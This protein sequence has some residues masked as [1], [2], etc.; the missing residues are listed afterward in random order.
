MDA[1]GAGEAEP[2]AKRARVEAGAAASGGD[3]PRTIVVLNVNGLASRLL[4]KDR[5]NASDAECRDAAAH[6]AAMVTHLFGVAGAPPD[7]VCLTE[8]RDGGACVR[9]SARDDTAPRR[10]GCLQVHLKAR[11]AAARSELEPLDARLVADRRQAE[12]AHAA[13]DTCVLRCQASCL[14]RFL[15]R[16]AL[17]AATPQAAVVAGAAGLHAALV[18]ARREAHRR[19]VRAAAAGAASRAGCAAA[20]LAGPG[21]PPGA[22]Q[23]PGP[24]GGAGVRHHAPAADLH[25][26][27]RQ[28]RRVAMFACFARSYLRCCRRRV[29]T[30]LSR[31]RVA[32][33]S[34]SSCCG[35]WACSMPSR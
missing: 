32:P 12:K 4:P 28:N 11:S 16:A 31:W 34:T 29:Q 24:R 2:S 13:V 23:R 26:K 15:E 9:I 17:T 20:L 6:A 25:A 19:R 21:R 30:Q 35:S 14:P 8:V 27:Q 18:A 1:A 33:R 5:D 3:D 7:V 10:C 22:A